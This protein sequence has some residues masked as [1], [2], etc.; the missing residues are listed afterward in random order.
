MNKVDRPSARP[1]EVD[2][3]LLDLFISL[4]ATDE[5]TEYPLAF[6]SAKEGWAVKELSKVNDAMKTIHPLLDMILE[7]VP[8]P[9]ADRDAPFSMLVTQI[10]S[11]AYLGKCYLGRVTSGTL[12]TGVCICTSSFHQIL[13]FK[14]FLG[15]NQISG[16]KWKCSCG[17]KMH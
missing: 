13:N 5:Q 15:Q 17:R 7:H 2:A 1:D 8:H 16:Y 9:V 6:A 12:K 4:E 10:E 11:N 14:T 3:D